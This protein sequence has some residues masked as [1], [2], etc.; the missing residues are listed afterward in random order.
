[1]ILPHYNYL[2]DTDIYLPDHQP[3]K[4]ADL[5]SSRKCL[6]L[7]SMRSVFVLV[8][9]YLWAVDASAWA[10]NFERLAVRQD[11]SVTSGVMSSDE[12]APQ[13]GLSE[14][15]LT[16]YHPEN[17]LPDYLFTPGGNDMPS[18][19]EA[20]VA[21]GSNSIGPGPE[22]TAAKT[23]CSS[24][25]DH[26]QVGV[27]ARKR[28]RRRVLLKRGGLCSAPLLDAP[29]STNQHPETERKPIDT[30]GNQ[31]PTGTEQSEPDL[32]EWSDLFKI[33][34]HGGDSPA[35]FEHT[36]GL[37]PIGVCDSLGIGPVPSRFD[38]YERKNP[39]IIPKAW[40]LNYCFLCAYS[41]QF[42]SFS[43]CKTG[44]YE[45]TARLIQ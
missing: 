7:S 8:L 22:L 30:L 5:Y 4:L 32:L 36:K 21:S 34:T 26:P 38:I 12:R 25:D 13:E 33:S 2:R 40:K 14:G 45:G 29:T 3:I 1:M 16:S 41:L 28:K 9:T 24:R 39:D 6:F 11:P 10:A 27:Q 31:S 20:L 17:A 42:N 15:L 37:L 35:C 23:E 18:A 43:S 44:R 19:N